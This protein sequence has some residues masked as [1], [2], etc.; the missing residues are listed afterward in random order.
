MSKSQGLYVGGIIVQYPAHLYSPV[1]VPTG[2]QQFSFP[3]RHFFDQKS[4]LW[5]VL[6]HSLSIFHFP[7]P[8]QTPTQLYHQI[9]LIRTITTVLHS[10]S[11]LFWK[12]RY[13]TCRFFVYAFFSVTPS[14]PDTYYRSFERSFRGELGAVKIV[15]IGSGEAEIIEPQVGGIELVGYSKG[16]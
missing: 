8:F 13:G 12:A 10:T 1:L 6:I 11:Y 7:N 3:I 9:E 4:C 2:I 15:G 14:S 16:E 5:A